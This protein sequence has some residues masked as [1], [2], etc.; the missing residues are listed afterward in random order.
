MISNTLSSRQWLEEI[1]MIIKKSL[2]YTIINKSGKFL[3]PCLAPG[4]N[5]DGQMCKSERGSRLWHQTDCCKA[6]GL[7]PTQSQTDKLVSRV[8]F[9]GD[10]QYQKY[11]KVVNFGLADVCLT[12]IAHS[13]TSER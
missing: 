10:K 7:G 6:C 11:I 13:V 9:P 12:S 4:S 3:H 8:N 2:L 5:G 1:I